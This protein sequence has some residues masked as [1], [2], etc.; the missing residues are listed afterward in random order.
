MK[1]SPQPEASNAPGNPSRLHLEG[2]SHGKVGSRSAGVY[3]VQNWINGRVYVGSAILLKARM[4]QHESA[5][6]SGM[7]GS[8]LLRRDLAQHGPES[9]H[10]F[11]LEIFEADE[12]GLKNKLRQTEAKWTYRLD[13]DTE[14]QGYNSMV[15]NSWT[16]GARLRDSERKYM[17]KRHYA[18]L[19]GVDLY[20]PIKDLLVRSWVPNFIRPD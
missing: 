11:P 5:L 18:L 3:A 19:P 16:D 20:D 2:Q 6:R 10:I 7:H 9:F 14:S 12:P 15:G 8:G 13:A 17:R 4:K 1:K